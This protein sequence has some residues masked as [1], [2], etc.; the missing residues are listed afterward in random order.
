MPT[1]D[2][3]KIIAEFEEQA[4]GSTGLLVTEYKGLKTVEFNELRQ[5]LRPLR[6]EYRVVKNSLT[7]IALKNAGL[8]A[9]ADALQG[10]AAVVIERGDPVATIK[11]LYEFSKTHENLKVKAGYFEGKVLS[12]QELKAIAALPSR[13]VLLATL[14]GTLQAPLIHL[15]GVLQAPVRDLACVLDA[16]AK[17]SAEK[18]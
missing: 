16:V 10:P 4:R 14:L 12:G 2:K 6:S 3:K 13:E 7:R 8:D 17:K 9:L 5:K 11:T 15:V 18:K 1:E